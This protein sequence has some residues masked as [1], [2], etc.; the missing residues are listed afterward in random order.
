MNKKELTKILCWDYTGTG[1]LAPWDYDDGLYGNGWDDCVAFV[2]ETGWTRPVI[3][4]EKK[5]Q[6]DFMAWIILKM[7]EA[8]ADG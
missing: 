6:G 4:N 7:K 3:G 2:K 1:E 5:F 8:H